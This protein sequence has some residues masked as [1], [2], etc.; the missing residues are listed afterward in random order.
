M[1]QAPKLLEGMTSYLFWLSDAQMA[2]TR[3]FLPK[4]LGKPQGVDQRVLS[5]MICINHSDFR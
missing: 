4:N 5:E 1:F 2:R 3:P